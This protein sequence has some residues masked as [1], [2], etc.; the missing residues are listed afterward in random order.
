MATERTRRRFLTATAALGTTV[1]AG[2]LGDD[3]VTDSGTSDS[4]MSATGVTDPAEASVV[5]ID[6]FSD[7]AGTL[8]ARSANADLPDPDEP[9]DFE[10]SPFLT[11]GL[12]P[13]GEVVE[14]Y[15][16]DVM[17]VTPAPIYAFMYEDGE[18]VANQLN[19]IGVIPGDPGYNDFWH[20]HHAI[21]PENYEPNSVTGVEE[22]LDRDDIEI[23]STMEIKNCPVVPEG[24]TAP[25][26]YGDEREQAPVIEGWYD[27]DIA[28]YL[29]F[30]E[31]TF[32]RTDDG[33]MPRSPIYVTFNTNY[34]REDGGPQTGF[35]TE[36][37]TDQTHNVVATLPGDEDYSSLW[38]VNTYDNAYFDDV[39]DLPSARN[40][41][42]VES[43]IAYVNC[44]IVS[45]EG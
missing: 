44:P 20:V 31:D 27:G 16:F 36:D 32:Q 5:E 42:L 40:A 6:R 24:S 15:N 7:D 13:D 37:G 22:L 10:Q 39:S 45:V 23:E 41:D 30:E 11:R 25:Q 19:V 35:V 1:I 34:D 4:G 3:G 8:F 28:P 18:P 43:G 14:Y 33:E 12:G 21:V 17:P 29:V 2:C 26:H 9:I 38:M